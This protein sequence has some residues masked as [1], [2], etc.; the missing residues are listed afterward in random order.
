MGV[1]KISPKN[2]GSY[3]FGDWAYLDYEPSGATV[4]DFVASGEENTSTIQS[5]KY[6]VL[7]FNTPGTFEF[8]FEKNGRIDFLLAGGGGAS[9][10]FHSDNVG[11]QYIGGG[12]A[13][14]F[15]QQLGYYPSGNSV[16]TVVVAQ[17]A[18]YPSTSAADG[19]IS[20]FNDIIAYGGGGGGLNHNSTGRN[21]ASG[22]GGTGSGTGGSGIVGQGNNGAPA[23]GTNGTGGGGAGGE[24]VQYL[25]GPGLYRNFDGTWR[26]YCAGGNAN[27]NYEDPQGQ[28]PY[29]S[30]G[31]DVVPGSGGGGGYYGGGTGDVGG[32]GGAKGIVLVRFRVG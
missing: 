17:G 20:S 9:S 12:G 27:R 5:A 2:A 11:A 29:N 21:G 15:V 30:I 23:D 31:R 6:R 3:G 16:N 7:F 1:S 32:K 10:G 28:T 19:D 8:S 18:P 14:G 26:W 25:G 13:G 4:F 22:G 24:G